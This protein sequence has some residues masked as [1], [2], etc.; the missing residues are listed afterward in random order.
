[1]TEI[2]PETAVAGSILVDARCL[3]DITA[4]V[5]EGDFSIAACEAIYR[6]AV[7]LSAEGIAVDPV[8]IKNTC[9]KAGTPVSNE[10]LMECMDI[11][12]T[13]NNA[14]MYAGM[15]REGSLR[16]SL[17][18]LAVEIHGRSANGEDPKETMDYVAQALQTIEAEDT[19]A[20]LRTTR[21]SI[22]DFLEYREQLDAGKVK[23]YVPTGLKPL[24]NLLG[25]GL[26]C[27]GLYVIG[28]RPGMGKTTLALYLADAVNQPVLF[29]S[30]EMG[31]REITAKR[32]ARESGLSYTDLLMGSLSD[33][34]YDR[35][36][37]ATVA[38][39][40]RPVTV[41]RKPGAS[42]QDIGRMARK[43]PGLRLVVVDYLGLIRP[44]SNKAG[45]YEAVTQISNDL[46]Q[47]ARMLGVP[48]VAL[49]QLNRENTGRV[50][51][52][53]TLADL[54]DSGAIEQDA[55]GVLLLHNEAYYER[56]PDTPPDPST[57]ALV[58]CILAKNR[59]GPTGQ[60]DLTVYFSSGRIYPVRYRGVG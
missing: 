22:R 52:R 54:R 11:T 31:E 46:K 56:K 8:S 39:G 50:D 19:A 48:V 44:A 2:N 24:D 38:V 18:G 57:P 17:L 10:F 14:G 21:D 3:Q 4:V 26:L 41:N 30:L 23:G 35:L 32:I 5:R 25:G 49:A 53:P 28:A 40:K 42:V 45:R 43:V 9:E 58:E 15:V 13:A 6:A 34:A 51:K 27:G 7:S 29:V 20:E 37:N 47:L 36:A 12:A 33:E 55:D 16:R 60:T 59:H 1:M